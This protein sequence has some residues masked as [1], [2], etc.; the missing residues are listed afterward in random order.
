METD[1]EIRPEEASRQMDD[2]A[3]GKMEKAGRGKG[4]KKFGPESLP[5]PPMSDR[6][7][8]RDNT[9]P[10]GQKSIPFQRSKT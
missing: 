9:I 6:K 1:D 3:S 4:Q 8:L 2:D 7:R 5:V 10:K